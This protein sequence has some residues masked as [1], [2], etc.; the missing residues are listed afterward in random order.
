MSNIE[1]HSELPG[2]QFNK[3]IN[4]KKW[5]KFVVSS[6]GKQILKLDYFFISEEKIIQINR[7]HLK[8]NYKTDIVT[9][10]YSFLKNISGEI[11]ICIP[12]VKINS[13]IYSENNFEYELMRVILHG[14]LHLIGYND[15]SEKEKIVMRKRENLYLSTLDRF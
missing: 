4:T 15:F 1:F 13:N 5:L 8:H 10:D 7:K 6:E 11:F 12:V 14:L 2:Y 9:F 3:S